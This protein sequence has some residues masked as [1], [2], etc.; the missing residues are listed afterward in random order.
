MANQSATEQITFPG[1]E[2]APVELPSLKPEHEQFC[3]EYVRMGEGKAAYLRVY[4]DTNP[5]TAK[6]KACKLLQ[7]DR[8]R[9]FIAEYR[10]AIRKRLEAKVIDY[11]DAVLEVDR[12]EF[13]NC[14]SL[15]QLSERAISILE[16]EQVSSKDGV[17]TLLKIPH[18]HQSA[19]EVQKMLG[20][21]K[22]TSKLEVTGKDGTPLQLTSLLAAAANSTRE[23]VTTE[24]ADAAGDDCQTEGS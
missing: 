13:M 14:S 19:V 16:F 24:E 11:H 7:K 1:M 22:E 3:R 15:D 6:V 20:M 17:R 18:R 21:N 23:L 5:D 10:L 4:Q 12:R 9:A 8:I 2:E